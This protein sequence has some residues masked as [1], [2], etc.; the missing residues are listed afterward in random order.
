MKFKAYA[1]FIKQLRTDRGWRVEFDVS[2]DQYE[3][4]NKLPLIP[5][6]TLLEITVETDDGTTG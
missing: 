4:I 6:D 3:L 5:E 2:E 1:P